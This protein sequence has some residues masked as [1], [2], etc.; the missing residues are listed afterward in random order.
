MSVLLGVGGACA[1]T[2]Q[3]V[4]DLGYRPPVRSRAHS[5]AAAVAMTVAVAVA[6]AV[7][8]CCFRPSPSN[9]PTSKRNALS[10]KGS[11]RSP[12]GNPLIKPLCVSCVMLLLFLAIARLRCSVAL[13]KGLWQT[14]CP[15]W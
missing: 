15:H 3:V 7:T 10:I 1:Q 4:L 6:V 8:F 9:N 14:I 12:L 13:Y 5:F 11:L 2:S